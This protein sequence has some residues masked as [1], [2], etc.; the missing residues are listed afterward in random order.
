MFHRYF[1]DPIRHGHRHGFGPAPFRRWREHGR[2]MGG[3]REGRVF[4]G[5]ELRLVILALI[6]EKPRHGYE[7]IKELGERVGGDY[8]PSP[9]VVYPT[10][11]LLEEMGYARSNQDE[12]GRKLYAVT[13]EGE[14]ALADNKTQIDAIFARFDAADDA[15]GRGG[16]GSVVRAMM[17]LRAATRLRLRGRAATP[18]Q[19]QAIV[20]ALDQAAKTIERT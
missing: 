5:G 18:E 7:I 11:T 6:A 2:G 20:D 8:S 3:G 17:N 13:P 9:G 14:K 15:I 19:V 16:I 10:L 4:D 12:A 1:D